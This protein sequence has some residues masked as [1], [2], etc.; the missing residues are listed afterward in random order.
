[1]NSTSETFVGS[2][3]RVKFD[4]RD[5]DFAIP[6]VAA[7]DVSDYSKPA[8]DHHL[9]MTGPAHRVGESK[10]A[11]SIAGSDR[12]AHHGLVR[13]V[14]GV[15]VFGGFFLVVFLGPVLFE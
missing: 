12:G 7:K 1:M 4:N 3:E 14:G 11:I 6:K 5:N 8:T 9:K 10:P 13:R 15:G 2:I